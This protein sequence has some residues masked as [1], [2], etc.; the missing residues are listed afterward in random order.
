MSKLT[1]KAKF[2]A[3]TRSSTARPP[4]MT[5]PIRIATSVARGPGRGCQPC[6]A[7]DESLETTLRPEV[8]S[9]H[10]AIDGANRRVPVEV[11][12]AATHVPFDDEPD[13]EALETMLPRR[14]VSPAPACAECL[15]AAVEDHRIGTRRRLTDADARWLDRLDLVRHIAGRRVAAL[16]RRVA[17]R[18]QPGAWPQAPARQPTSASRVSAMQRARRDESADALQQVSARRRDGKAL[19][20]ERRVS[21]SSSA[22][23]YALASPDVATARSSQQCSRS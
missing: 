8:A 5:K 1:G 14:G 22:A 3:C 12:P 11:H 21:S 17:R 13:P 4:R 15:V 10:A 16:A 9:E 20:R 6:P 7:E 2:A 19:A 23:A 18:L